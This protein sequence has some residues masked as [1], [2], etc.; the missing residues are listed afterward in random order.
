[1]LLLD[2]KLGLDW[3]TQAYARGFDGMVWHFV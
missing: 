3:I 1:M 2:L